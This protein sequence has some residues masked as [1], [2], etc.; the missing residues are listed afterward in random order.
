MI[1]EPKQ[2]T[3]KG[4]FWD[5][6][7][8]K[9]FL[10]LFLYESKEI[11]IIEWDKFIMS[12]VKN[13]KAKL[14]YQCSFFNA[15]Y[16]YKLVDNKIF[17]DNDFKNLLLKKFKL[18]Q[19]VEV[20]L[21]NQIFNGIMH[22]NKKTIF[23]FYF[24]DIDIYNKVMYI[25]GDSGVYKAKIQNKKYKQKSYLTF[26]NIEET[27]KLNVCSMKV[28]RNKIIMSTQDDGL[29]EYDNYIAEHDLD[30]PSP[31]VQLC[32]KHS[33]FVNFNYSSILSSSYIDKSIFLQRDYRKIENEKK[34]EMYE[35]NKFN[36]SDIFND[37]ENKGFYFSYNNKIYQ[38]LKDTISYCLFN[39]SEN[40]TEKVFYSIKKVYQSK[41]LEKSKIIN[42]SVETFGVVI[43]FNNKIIVLLSDGS[44]KEYS[45]NKDNKIVSYRTYPKSN[46]YTNQLHIIYE[47]KL[48]IISFN[49]DYFVNNN[50]K[51]FGIK[52]KYQKDEK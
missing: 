4:K 2:I 12:C 14:A 33:S 11:K 21:N 47:N 37:K 27:N 24:S 31:L 52:Y 16:L 5:V 34:L 15:D 6:F 36:I 51:D 1:I 42:A 38:I 8:Y 19:Y 43:Q 41:G 13:K 22:G 50:E 10:Y 23:P 29:Y 7:L 46:C 3:I 20:D 30:Y 48:D 32:K 49:H 39:Q 9:N 28:L 17:E 35:K 25:S 45:E 26:E 44:L 40:T 18:M